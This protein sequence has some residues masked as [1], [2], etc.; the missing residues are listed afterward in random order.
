MNA[1][2]PVM[3][4]ANQLLVTL[5]LGELP[6]HLPSV[7]ACKRYGVRPAERI[8]G[9][10]LDRLLRHHAGAALSARLHNSRTR[11]DERPHVPGARR[12]DDIEQLSGVARVLRI[13][14]QDDRGIPAL[15]D[16]LSQCR[17]VE[18]VQADQLCTAPFDQAPD[19]YSQAPDSVSEQRVDEQRAWRT[20]EQIHLPEALGFEPGDPAV[21]VGLADTGVALSHHEL[22]NVL[23][24]GF[25]T[26]DLNQESV[27]AVKLV[28]DYQHID[29][30]PTDDV[31]HGTGCAGILRAQGMQL[32]PGGA[33]LCSLT[34][35]RVLGAS[36]SG[37][38]RVG[39]GSLSNIDAGM[40]RLIDLNA[41]VINM[42]FGTA[43][44]ALTENA[45]LPHIEVIR[46]ALARDVMLIA[47]S[48]NSG[49]AERYYPAAHDG[50]IAVGSVSE[51]NHPSRFTTRGEHVCVCAPGEQIWTAGLAGYQRAS[52]TSFAA[53]FVSA[54]IALM[55]SY[56][57]RRAQPLS[58]ALAKSILMHSATPFSGNAVSGCGV[59]IIN[60]FAALKRLQYTLDEQDESYRTRQG[61]QYG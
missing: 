22:G 46:Y 35:V 39:I 30:D 36:L 31:G 42:S 2:L 9:G 58:P 51:Q 43:E 59:G 28:G 15:L 60:A 49:I 3:R 17:V 29:G 13:K 26:V 6:E 47:A 25:D 7:L 57:Q 38:K 54:V 11:H 48:G 16:A 45:P 24:R 52:G 10:V 4:R 33:G 37:E 12:Y 53:P 5:K 27:G 23:R 34:P 61:A 40:K 21:I 20:H 1:S 18:R 14:V 41:R 44:S 56:A 50:V 8:D 32:P 19:L 55:L